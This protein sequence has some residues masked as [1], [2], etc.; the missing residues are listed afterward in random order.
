MTI[1]EADRL[2]MHEGLRECM[3][4]KVADLLMEH[5]P[6]TGWADV[7][8]VQDLNQ[9]E[10]NTDIQFVAVRSQIANL[11]NVMNTKFEAVRNRLENLEEKM[12]TKFESVD[13]RFDNLTQMMNVQFSHINGRLDRMF[14]A[15]L[16]LAGATAA[17]FGVVAGII[18]TQ[19]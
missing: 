3:T 17:G 7:A 9:L 16:A 1:T 15:L 8:R 6:P 4:E 5:L 14:H 12:D 10:K 19:H 2:F 13:T 18:L 11:E